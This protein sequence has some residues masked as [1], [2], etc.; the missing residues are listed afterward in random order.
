MIRTFRCLPLG[1]VSVKGSDWCTTLIVGSTIW[2][3]CRGAAGLVVFRIRVCE[4]AATYAR[5][6]ELLKVMSCD[7]EPSEAGTNGIG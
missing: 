4:R 7:S 1:R 6:P 5:E 2:L 3:I